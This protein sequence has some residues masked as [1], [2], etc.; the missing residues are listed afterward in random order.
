MIVLK[1]W[2]EDAYYSW[3]TAG[4]KGIIEAATGSGKTFIGLKI[5]ENSIWETVLVVVPTIQLMNQWTAEIQKHTGIIAGNVGGGLNT[6][7]KVTVAVINSVRNFTDFF[8][9]IIL[10][11]CHHYLSDENIKILKQKKY[12]NIVGLSATEKRDDGKDYFDILGITV[13]YKYTQK[14]AIGNGD[15]AK[16]SIKN[17]AVDLT[18]DE[19]D[20][21]T[22][23]DTII[24]EL[25]PEYNYSLKEI[26]SGNWNPAKGKIRKA[27]NQR[28]QIVSNAE[29]K[30]KKITEIIKEYQNKKIIVFTEYITTAD[31][32]KKLLA[33]EFIESKVYH[34]KISTE[35]KKIVITDFS[36]SKCNVLIA[37]KALDEGYDVPDCDVGIIFAGNKTARQIIQRTGRILRPKSYEVTLYQ[38]YVADTIDEKWLRE[39]NRSLKGY[40]NIEY[41]Y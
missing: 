26:F 24:K 30:Y 27:I 6:A 22:N 17:I 29:A 25:M 18:Q 20:K 34:S 15:L 9:T 32:I 28:K 21:Y 2:Q 1:E 7:S 35:N 38:I 5:I 10:D 16:Y 12:T 33:Y 8:S 3:K 13:V 19:F 40:N 31:K 37:V 39:R 23:Y 41:R 4:Q 36:S 11:E 14:D